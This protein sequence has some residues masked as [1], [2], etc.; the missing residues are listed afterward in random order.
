MRLHQILQA[1]KPHEGKDELVIRLF[2]VYPHMHHFDFG[3][4]D[5]VPDDEWKGLQLYSFD[6]IENDLFDVPYEAFSFAWSQTL[7]TGATVDRIAACLKLPGEMAGH[8]EMPVV[9]LECW[10]FSSAMH[11]G[12][13]AYHCMHTAFSA[14]QSK[15]TG[16][17][18]VLEPEIMPM[19]QSGIR[20][21]P[22]QSELD[23]APSLVGD[24]TALVALLHADGVS[25]RTS[26]A[27]MRLNKVRAA[28]GKVAIGPLSQVFVN[29][30][31]RQVAPSGVTVGSHASPRMH[32]R[33]GHVRRLQD[34]K[35]TNVRPC[36]VG[37]VGSAEPRDYKVKV[38]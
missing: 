5:P 20:H 19:Q 1:L 36:L 28:K 34:G 2:G 15:Q 38:A 9:G 27:P 22:D 13:R 33:R 29:V 23:L 32:W 7:P 37:S 18:M 21:K 12:Q 26:P 30:G 14:L 35:I 11:E 25:M 31:K 24:M 17:L 3:S 10:L 6:L 8:P 4:I 16:K